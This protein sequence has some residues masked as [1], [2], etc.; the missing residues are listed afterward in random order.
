MRNNE[1]QK[2]P[3]GI[4]GFDFITL[5]GLPRGR[6]TLITGP[7]GSG[8]TM[9]AMAFLINGARDYDEP[10]VYLGFEETEE[11][12]L[13]NFA[14]FDADL[15]GLIEAKK[16][17]VDHV[18]AFPLN[19]T[20]AGDYDLNGL[21]VRLDE[22][23]RRMDAKR[24]VLDAFPALFAGFQRQ[25]AVR[26]G[27]MQLFRFLKDRGVTAVATA[28]SATEV[29]RYGLGRSL[30]DC[31]IHLDSQISG[32]VS[33]RHL[34]VAKYRGS[35]HQHDEF[36]FLIG[37]DGLNVMPISSVQQDYA[38]SDKRITTGVHGLDDMLEGS[39]FFRGSS[40]L[41]SGEA[42]TGKSSLAA[43]FAGSACALG[44]R[45]LYCAFEESR[46]EVV[47]NMRSIGLNLQDSIDRGLLQIYVSRGTA[48]D[49]E[50]HLA[51]LERLVTEFQPSVIVL[52][53]VS[54]LLRTGLSGDVSSMVSRLVDFLKSRG[55]TSMFT[56]LN[57]SDVQV[58]VGEHENIDISSVMDAWI[59]LTNRE[60]NGE[61]TRLL[62]IAKARGMA[63][64]NQVRE[65]VITDDKIQ[66]EPVYV[67]G[68]QVL[69]GTARVAQLQQDRSEQ[70]RLRQEQEQL[71][72]EY[73]YRRLSVENQI[74]A[75]QAELEK[76][77]G[78][79]SS[80]RRRFREDVSAESGEAGGIEHAGGGEGDT[81][82]GGEGNRGSKQ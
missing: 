46:D 47:R 64:S 45:S 8:K 16:L 3:V 55:V 68:S 30:S 58:L 44:E 41:V 36:P 67:R 73:Q 69:T 74:A 59:R 35:R 82:D 61:Q 50:M 43:H 9:F 54:N 6:P 66:L 18:E 79:Y 4:G 48:Y 25:S 39:G 81:E 52:D 56:V 53:P 7:A 70:D 5:G 76:V 37:S 20:E 80:S 65:F 11:E 62:S 23:L 38:A 19:T 15:P 26:A 21:F 33:T 13:E 27:L 78:D 60:A 22:T 29:A 31:V 10:G 40:V 14:S 77:K 72:R 17:F 63:H 51:T 28:E 49:L 71:E 2:T 24:L 75:L 1:I 34:R 12:L 57:R 42:G 32:H